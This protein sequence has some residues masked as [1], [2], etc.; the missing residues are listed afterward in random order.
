MI[1][2][3][4]IVWSYCKEVQLW[5]SCQHFLVLCRLFS[6]NMLETTHVVRVK[7][8]IERWSGARGRGGLAL[9]QCHYLSLIL[10]LWG[11]GSLRLS[12][13]A[14]NYKTI[15]VWC[16]L[17]P[18]SYR[19]VL[20]FNLCGLP[21]PRCS[22]GMCCSF[23]LFKLSLSDM[24]CTWVEMWRKGGI[25]KPQKFIDWVGSKSGN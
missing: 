20:C 14:A 7:F 12:G 16:H 1:I 22:E 15:H 13:S 21:W 24:V 17:Y 2:G 10:I 19:N 23:F 18:I 9:I 4:L 5:K 8:D 6:S 11:K 3:I 25:G